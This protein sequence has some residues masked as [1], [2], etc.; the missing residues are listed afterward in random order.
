MPQL[1]CS[2]WGSGLFSASLLSEIVK[3]LI[4]EDPPL[5]WE[6]SLLKR[7]AGPFMTL[8]PLDLLCTSAQKH[9]KQLYRLIIFLYKIRKDRMRR[10]QKT[11]EFPAQIHRARR[12]QNLAMVKGS[13]TINKEVIQFASGIRS[14]NCVSRD[15]PALCCIFWARE[16]WDSSHPS[17]G[18]SHKGQNLDSGPEESIAPLSKEINPEYSLEGL[19]L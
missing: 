11:K 3:C 9:I 17:R 8:S 4:N 7:G 6:C 12:W 2:S 19:M 14:W 16:L 10:V 15:G 1:S 5:L 18:S 13:E